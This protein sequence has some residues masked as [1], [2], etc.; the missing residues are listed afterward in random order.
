MKFITQSKFNEYIKL[1][2]TNFVKNIKL[3][4]TYYIYDDIFVGR[5]YQG[6]DLYLYS[7]FIA[8]C[9]KIDRSDKN[10]TLIELTIVMSTII[11]LDEVGKELKLAL[12]KNILKSQSSSAVYCRN[13]DRKPGSI[14]YYTL[15]VKKNRNKKKKRHT[16]NTPI[17]RYRFT[18]V[19]SANGIKQLQEVIAYYTEHGD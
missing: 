18:N 4:E 10:K 3:N 15:T 6:V 2:K 19:F 7:M 13:L 1:A 12:S 11:E 16:S 5:N 17:Q 9:T 8:I 14:V